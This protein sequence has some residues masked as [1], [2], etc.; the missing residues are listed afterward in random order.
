ML[1]L[2][3]QQKVQHGRFMLH[4]MLRGKSLIYIKI[5]LSHRAVPKDE[6]IVRVAMQHCASNRRQTGALAL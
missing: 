2:M 4:S 5:R 1:R 3:L 6:G